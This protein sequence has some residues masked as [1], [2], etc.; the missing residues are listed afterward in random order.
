M[1]PT[2]GL[3]QTTEKVSPHPNAL[4]LMPRKTPGVLPKGCYANQPGNYGD[5]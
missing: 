1:F 2:P 4:L 3:S 5:N